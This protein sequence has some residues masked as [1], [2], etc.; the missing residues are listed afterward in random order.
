MS[1]INDLT[2]R[3]E[4][5]EKLTKLTE[6][7]LKKLPQGKLKI[8]KH[9]SR[10]YYYRDEGQCRD[11]IIAKANLGLAKQLAQRNY[12]ENVLRASVAEG[13]FLRK[14]IE[15][16]P[17]TIP[18]DVYSH[19]SN[20]RKQ[21]VRPILLPDDQFIKEWQSK[22]YQ[23]KPFRK[24]DPVYITMRGE[25]VRSKSEMIIAD[26]LYANNIPYKYECPVIINGILIHPDFTILRIQDRKDLFL[27]HCGRIGDKDY[28]D[29]F[30]DRINLYS[31]NGIIVGDRLFLT[32]E[33]ANR[34][35]DVRTIDRLITTVFTQKPLL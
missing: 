25:R 28:S 2:S 15:K 17:K 3:F 16:Y 18:E 9:S 13:K 22:P 31:E 5:I 34:P 26:R 29:D 32:F 11:K 30:V 6:E 4:L 27:E 23:P 7:K 10:I 35:L 12:L 24:D 19:L 8:K 1:L 33:T 21:L 14:I 20:E